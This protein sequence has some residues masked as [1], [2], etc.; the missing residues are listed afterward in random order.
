MYISN[1]HIA[2]DCQAS[3]H[4]QDLEPDA[5]ILCPFCHDAS[6]LTYKLLRIQPDLHPVVQQ[7]KEWSQREGSHKDSNEAKLE[8]WK[9][10]ASQCSYGRNWILEELAQTIQYL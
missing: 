1:T 6:R 5:D 7:C 10:C 9:G 8:N 3:Q 2:D 4:V